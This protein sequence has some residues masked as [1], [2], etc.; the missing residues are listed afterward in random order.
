MAL[1][2]F[3]VTDDSELQTDVRDLTSY[4]DSPDELPATQFDGIIRS[5]KRTLY[6]KTGSDKWYD[7]TA[8]GNALVMMAALKAKE[9]VENVNIDSYG[10][11]DESLSFHN[12][13]PDD[14]QQI[15]SWSGEL[16]ESLEKSDVQF[17]NEQDLAFSNTSSYIG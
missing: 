16:N 9:A 11:A 17:D 8:Y 1:P 14:S 13:D 4:N 7:D 5:A 6:V 2:T 15:R 12:A 10:I 3:A